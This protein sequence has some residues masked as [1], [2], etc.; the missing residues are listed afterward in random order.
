MAQVFLS[1]GDGSFTQKADL[2]DPRIFNGDLTNL[3]VGDFNADGKDDFLRQEKGAFA[4]DNI[5]M[6]QVFLN[7]TLTDNDTLIGGNGDDILTGGAGTDILTGGAGADKFVF[8]NKFEGIDIIKDFQWTEGDKIQ[9]SALSF[10]A[11]SLN[12]FSYNSS[13]GALSF[14]DYQFAIIENKPAGFA[15]SLDVHLV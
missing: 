1:N 13:N 10:G 9:I 7:N 6:A 2:S 5:L 12:Q 14:V 3:M 15:V 4:N 11:T 8:N